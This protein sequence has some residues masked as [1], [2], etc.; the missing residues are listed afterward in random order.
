VRS[1][2]PCIPAQFS[3]GNTRAVKDMLACREF[4]PFS[5]CHRSGAKFF[6]SVTIVFEAQFFRLEVLYLRHNCSSADGFRARDSLG[7]SG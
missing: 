7:L 4:D 6:E 3:T 2:A 1:A 5:R